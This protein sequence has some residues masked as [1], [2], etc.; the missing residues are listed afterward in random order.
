MRYPVIQSRGL[1]GYKLA[2]QEHV[3]IAEAKQLLYTTVKKFV[4]S[5]SP[6]ATPSLEQHY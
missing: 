1:Y 4:L 2:G 6:T 5:K 3:N